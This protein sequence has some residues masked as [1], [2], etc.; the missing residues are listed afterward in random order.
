MFKLPACYVR[1]YLTFI[2]YIFRQKL[3]AG[4]TDEYKR[5]DMGQITEESNTTKLPDDHNYTQSRHD[6]N[7]LCHI[8]VCW[9]NILISSY[10]QIIRLT[11]VGFKNVIVL[12]L[13]HI[14]R[15]W[16]HHHIQGLLTI[17][18]TIGISHPRHP[19]ISRR[20]LKLCLIKKLPLLRRGKRLNRFA[21]LSLY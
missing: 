17:C 13:A 8:Q 21:K 11:L 20:D 4:R 10:L 12:F 3:P 15:V 6:W 2:L 7:I 14:H 1:I 16:S 18:S 9:N 5:S 19:R